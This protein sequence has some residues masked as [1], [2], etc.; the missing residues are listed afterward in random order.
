MNLYE[1][2]LSM[3][4]LQRLCHPISNHS[5]LSELRNWDVR[6]PSPMYPPAGMVREACCCLPSRLSRLHPVLPLQDGCPIQ[7]TP[8]VTY[9]MQ[10]ADQDGCACTPDPE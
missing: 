8:G 2:S 10:R 7:G 4:L 6:V 9:A 5:K 1:V 3:H